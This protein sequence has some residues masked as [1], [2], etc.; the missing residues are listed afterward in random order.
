MAGA[1]ILAVEGLPY[2]WVVKS[3]TYR[4]QDITDAGLDISGRQQRFDEV[5]VVITDVASEV[6]GIVRDA[7]GAAVPDATVLI[8]PLSE[9]FWTRTGR[10]LG[11][12]RTD[13]GGRYRVRGLPA[14][15]DPG[16]RVSRDGRKRSVSPRPAE[17]LPRDRRSPEPEASRTAGARSPLSSMTARTGGVR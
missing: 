9:T 10:R 5:R 7:A 16:R 6:S 1:H 15:E 4:G 2:P 17:E 13:A 8:V 11:V 14:G 3:V 12:L